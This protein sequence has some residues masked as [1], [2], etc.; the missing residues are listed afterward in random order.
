MLNR[1]SAMKSALAT[2]AVPAVP[3]AAALNTPNGGNKNQAAA[4]KALE[5]YLDAYEDFFGVQYD[6]L[7]DDV[8]VDESNAYYQGRADACQRWRDS[9]KH[10]VGLV[11]DANGRTLGEGAAPSTVCAACVD[12]GDV[13]LV[14]GGNSDYEGADSSSH[15]NCISFQV[16]PRS[17]AMRRRL[18]SMPSWE[19]GDDDTCRREAWWY[20]SFLD[21]RPERE[22]SDD[23]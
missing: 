15:M 13:L 14:V 23:E 6:E 12:L 3:L 10:L 7:G 1:R 11:L 16:V 18:E 19:D 9:R 21:P 17:P 4:R 5:E 8:P 22:Y 2:V 20:R